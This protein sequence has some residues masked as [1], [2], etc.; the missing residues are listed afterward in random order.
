MMPDDVLPDKREDWTGSPFYQLGHTPEL[1]P[2]RPKSV[3][4]GEPERDLLYRGPRPHDRECGSQDLVDRES[5]DWKKRVT[6]QEDLAKTA[7]TQNTIHV[8][9]R[10]NM[11]ETADANE[12]RE[13]SLPWEDQ[14][15]QRAQGKHRTKKD[16]QQKG[17]SGGQKDKQ[18]KL[19][20]KSLDEL[21]EENERLKQ[22]VQENQLAMMLMAE[23]VYTKEE[24]DNTPGSTYTLKRQIKQLEV[25]RD[26]Y[27][28]ARLPAPGTV[29]QLTGLETWM[30]GRRVI[31][32]QEQLEEQTSTIHFQE[33]DI[34]RKE[35]LLI[36]NEQRVRAA[37]T[38]DPHTT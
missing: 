15:A 30:D 26:H 20:Q 23:E 32:V 9:Q 33:E 10:R 19:A 31:D 18:Q 34:R 24:A 3:Q 21:R 27:A 17:S 36:D 1:Y 38:E 16:E 25:E 7:V 29:C 5:P 4:M 11:L 2:S 8:P 12:L 35:Q 28:S 37:E 14:A 6:G 22:Q 13:A